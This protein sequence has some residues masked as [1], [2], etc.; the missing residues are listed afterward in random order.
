MKNSKILNII[1]EMKQFSGESGKFETFSSKFNNF[2]SKFE[3]YN[4][5]FKLFLKICEFYLFSQSFLEFLQIL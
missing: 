1:L 4:A 2:P 3:N 5:K